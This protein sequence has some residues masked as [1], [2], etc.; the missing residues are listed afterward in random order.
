MGNISMLKNIAYTFIYTSSTGLSIITR[1]TISAVL[2]LY[3]LINPFLGLKPLSNLFYMSPILIMV[4]VILYI[5]GSFRKILE[6]LQ[7]VAIFIAIGL[8]INLFARLLNLWFVDMASVAMA[9]LRGALMFI[10]IALIFQWTKIEEIKWFLESIG[11]SELG[12]AI[13]IAFSRLPY[14]IVMYSE[15]LL[16]VKLKYG[17]RYLYRVILPMILYTVNHAREITEAIYIHGIPRCPINTS[18]KVRD[19]VIITTTSI[20]LLICLYTSI[21]MDVPP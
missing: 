13:A 11:L 19:I 10:V 16:T 2:L 3:L 5:S 7:F 18:I 21:A 15:A 12:A 4:L 1:I 6:G 9:S 8:A 20:I 14:I 17:S